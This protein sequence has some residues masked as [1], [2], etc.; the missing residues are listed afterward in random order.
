M[1]LVDTALQKREE[2][3]NLLQ[4]GLVGAG[5]ISSGLVNQ[6]EHY[7]PGMRVAAIANRT[8]SKAS[9]CYNQAGIQ[10]VSTVTDAESVDLNV[11]LGKYSVCQDPEILCASTKIDI[12]VEVTGTINYAAQV[13]LTAIEYKKPILL[14]NPELDATLGPILKHYADQAGVIYSQSDGDQ[15]GVI[16]NKYRFVKG[17]GLTPLVCGNIKG[18]LDVHKNPS[19]MAAYAK[20]VNNSVNMITSF[21][22]GTKVNFEQA[23]VANSTGMGVTRRGM[24][25]H[26][27]KEHIDHLT[28]F[29]DIDQ[30]LESGGIVDYIIGPKPS[31]GVY[32]FGTTDDPMIKDYL[33]YL[34]MGEGPL[35]SF[36]TPYH[37]CNLEI[38]NSS[39]RVAHFNDPVM[40]PVGAPVVEVVATAKRDLRTGE[41]LDGIGG[42]TCYG[43]CENTKIIQQENLLPIGLADNVVLKRDIKQGSALTFDDIEISDDR[44]MFQLYKQQQE[45]ANANNLMVMSA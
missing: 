5:F 22:D 7:I 23:N 19:D 30:L 37:L 26:R 18:F 31:P 25:A 34:K 40:V 8:L 3:G 45:F 13:V 12:I 11:E 1:V 15:P 35:Y 36:Y 39:A 4:V 6:I 10:H 2:Q 16:M 28:S 27:S 21:T 32:V 38:P 9:R 20:K 33:K 41:T 42:Y 14:F 17:L 44:L 43:E 24:S 29:Y